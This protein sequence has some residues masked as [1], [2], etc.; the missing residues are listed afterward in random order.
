MARAASLRGRAL[1]LAD[2]ELRSYAPVL[3]ALRRPASDPE[4][5]QRLDEALAIAAVTPL[6]IAATGAELAE[7]AAQTARECSPHLSGDAITAAVL[8]D[9]ACC[10]ASR[11]VEI[12]LSSHAGDPRR[13][14][15]AQF[16]R[17]AAASREVA[18]SADT[19]TRSR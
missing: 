10:A 9:G 15:A 18:L 12:N 3:E 4:R 11:L 13:A 14:Q 16:A 8:A 17:E 2:A 5:A 7:L 1:E 6:Q 19:G